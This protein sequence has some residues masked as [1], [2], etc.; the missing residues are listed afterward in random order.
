MQLVIDREYLREAVA[1]A[2]KAVSSRTTIPI[3]SG[4]LC[5]LTENEFI[6]TGSDSD[7]SIR[8]TIPREIDDNKVFKVGK[9]GSIVLP[10]K[11]FTEIV[12]KLPEGQVEIEVKDQSIVH[13]RSSHSEFQLNGLDAQEYPRL[14]YIEENK[15]L[16]LP[17]HL[18]KNLIRQTSFAVSTQESKPILTGVHCALKHGELKLVATD[19]HRLSQRIVKV[20]TDESLS[21]ENVVIPGKSLA[22]LQR[23]LIDDDKPIEVVITNNQIL[24]KTE[25]IL[26]FS[27][28]LDGTYPDTERIIPQKSQAEIT[29]NTKSLLQAIERASVLAKDGKHNVQLTSAEQ[30]IHISSNSP[31]VGRVAEEVHVNNMVGDGFK[32]AFNAKYALDALRVIDSEEVKIEFTGSMSPL[33]LRSLDD[34][35]LLQLILPIRIYENV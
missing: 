1:Q 10:A 17:S 27:R 26:F 31:E 35:Q 5:T 24:V 25:R 23:I 34:Q 2:D 14:P 20:E 4:I 8:V 11:Y 6:L 3:L 13:I 30:T 21:F 19:S 18:F 29:L 28:L 12:K 33:V 15:V 32:I 7:L 22:E 9:L 16:T